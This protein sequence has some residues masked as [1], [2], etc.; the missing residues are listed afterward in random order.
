MKWLSLQARERVVLERPTIG[1]A[2]LKASILAVL[3]LPR[4]RWSIRGTIELEEGSATSQACQPSRTEYGTLREHLSSTFMRTFRSNNRAYRAFYERGL[5]RHSV[6]W[7]AVTWSCRWTGGQRAQSFL[8]SSRIW[9]M[10]ASGGKWSLSCSFSNLR[11]RFSR[12]SI[13]PARLFLSAITPPPSKSRPQLSPSPTRVPAM[14]YNWVFGS[15]CEPS[16][17]RSSEVL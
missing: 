4:A 9:F 5:R 3:G 2:F 10:R 14:E 15:L 11:I 1:H 17:Q 13:R 7:Y 12:A 6:F 16:L 8:S